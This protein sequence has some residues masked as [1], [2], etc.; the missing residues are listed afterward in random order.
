MPKRKMTKGEKNMTALIAELS[1][2]ISHLE[3][4]PMLAPGTVAKLSIS[5]GDMLS[6]YTPHALE[7]NVIRRLRDEVSA[8]MGFEVP[9]I[10]TWGEYKMG[11]FQ[12][13]EL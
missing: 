3:S 5:P 9:V 2:R 1:A 8:Q 12:K 10:H 11:L 6:L 4:Q 7:D 13:Q